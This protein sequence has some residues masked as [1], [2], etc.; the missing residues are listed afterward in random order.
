MHQQAVNARDLQVVRAY[1]RLPPDPGGM[2]AHIARLSAEQR[3]QGV[4]VVNVF[5]TGAAEDAGVRVASRWDL[6]RVKPASLR[7]FIFYA[8]AVG[9]HSR[10]APGRGSVLH[11]HGDWSDFM[12][13]K[14]LARSLGAPLTVASAH[15]KLRFDRPAL[16]R[17]SLSHCGLVFAT[18]RMEQR[19]LQDTLGKPV[20]HL[21][22][23]PADLFFQHEAAAAQPR[24]DVVTV[25]SCVP[26]KR[27]G[28]VL[29]CAARCPELRFLVL[30]DGPQRQALLQRAAS[31]GIRNV[32][33][34]GRA[35]PAEVKSAMLLSRLFLLTSAEEGTPT[36]VLEAMAT[37]LPVVLTPSN[38]YGWLVRQG[39]NGTVTSTWA[40]EEVTAAIRGLLSDESRRA[41]MGRANQ[42]VAALHR[43][44][45]LASRI[46]ELMTTELHRH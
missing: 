32:A 17:A 46:T 23:A 6:R 18:G 38:D 26:V 43:W 15:G 29:D 42:E 11:V 45:A 36:V 1:Y 39:V 4:Q 41:A 35:S 25:A 19:F 5:N 20:H 28:L 16:Y 22:S 30:G 33:L 7:N 24:Y 13:S 34:P 40:P 3:R 21:P 8:A 27:L 37:G 31:E 14:A 12:Y 10:I 44:D 2:E 9:A